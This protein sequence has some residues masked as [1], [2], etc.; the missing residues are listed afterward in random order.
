M[1]SSTWGMCVVGLVVFVEATTA[2]AVP[3]KTASPVV[4]PKAGSA[5]AV[6]P[7]SLTQK[8]P[9]F[10]GLVKLAAV[11]PVVGLKLYSKFPQ[12][13]ITELKP[14][15][16]A[17]GI[18][19]GVHCGQLL[20]LVGTFGAKPGGMKLVFE[21][22][23]SQRIPLTV[24][25]WSNGEIHFFAPTAQALGL[26]IPPPG[27]DNSLIFKNG[28]FLIVDALGNPTAGATGVDVG[29]NP[30]FNDH[31]GDGHGW[32][33]AGGDDCDDGDATRYPGN[34][35]RPDASGHDEDCD[36]HSFG[37]ADE[38]EDRWCSAEAFNTDPST[39]QVYRGDDCNDHKPNIHPAQADP[40]NGYDDNCDGRIDEDNLNC[41]TNSH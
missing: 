15:L 26:T 36:P 27:A 39:G 20:T 31:D 34:T 6:K 24:S 21:V 30:K 1:K 11:R 16:G 9:V 4:V 3:P 18:Y 28:S 10:P 33:G 23:P 32:A 25:L 37:C 35:E 19:G 17:P 29:L 8:G 14:G 12:I 40:C 22:A 38:D 2:D 41:P 7:S 5:V 13:K